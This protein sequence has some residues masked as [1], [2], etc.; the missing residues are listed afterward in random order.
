M[1]STRESGALKL[2]RV[3]RGAEGSYQEHELDKERDI[4]RMCQ[5]SEV[6]GESYFA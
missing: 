4:I 6:E 3:R 2:M 5:E 1:H